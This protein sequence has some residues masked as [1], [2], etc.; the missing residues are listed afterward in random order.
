M[1]QVREVGAAVVSATPPRSLVLAQLM[2]QLLRTLAELSVHPACVAP[3]MQALSP[4]AAAKSPVLLQMQALRLLC[5]MWQHNHR[6]FSTLK[7]ALVAK[8]S[9]NVE[10]S[11]EMRL[12]RAACVLD[13]CTDDPVKGT[14]LV[15]LIQSGLQDSLPGVVALHLQSL[16]TLCEEDVVDFYTAWRVVRKLVPTRP[17][18]TQAGAAWL[19][20]LGCGGLD[21]RLHEPIATPLLASLW[22]GSDAACPHVRAAAAAALLCFGADTVDELL[23]TALSRYAP[24]QC[25]MCK[26][27]V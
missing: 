15:L 12:A 20:L 5:R 2:M 7:A 8:D 1:L 4:L 17:D 24:L 9:T 22:H 14:E 27:N 3:L 21:A 16:C 26:N 6:C 10:T 23:A 25:T 11:V 19:R 13:V 18:D